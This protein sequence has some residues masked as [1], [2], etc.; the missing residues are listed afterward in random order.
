MRDFPPTVTA[1]TPGSS[2]VPDTRSAG[3]YLWWIVRQ[4]TDLMLAGCLCSL[5]WMLPT[6]LTPWVFGR[7]IDEGIVP[8]DPGR[9]ALWSLVLL[10]ITLVGGSSGVFY[11]TVVVRSWLV[12]SYG[13]TRLVT[14]KTARLGHVMTRRAPTGEVLSVSGGDGEQF[15]HFV[16]IVSRLVGNVVAYAA[17]A[18]IVLRI[19]VP[20]GLVVLLVAPLLVV[21]SSALLRPLSAAQTRERSRDS[22]LTSM[23][24]DIVAGLRILR[25]IGGE[26]IFGDNYARQSQRVR[27]A[28][29]QAGGWAALVEA[30]G[31]LL[32]GLFLVALLVLGVRAVGRG[33]LQIG[34]L[35]TF[36]GYA[37][38]LV[39]P[40]RVV[41][42]AAQQ[43]TRSFVSARKTIGVLGTPDPW[44]QR[45]PQVLDPDAELVDEAS[46][47]RVRP[48]LLTM[49]VS[50]VPDDSAAL[51]DRLGRYL[52]GAD[53][54]PPAD[55]EATGR[56]ARRSRRERER[57]RAQLEARD[58]ERAT[59]PWGVRLGG[60]DLAQVPLEQVRDTVLVSD[61]GSHV[62]AGTLQ[63]AV[64]PHGRLSR[65]EAEAALRAAAA[66]D[67]YDILPGGWQGVLDERGRGL[68]G[69]QRQRLVLTRAL[70]ADAPV[71]VLV[72]PT[73]A[74]DAHTEATIAQRL[75]GHRRG[76][77]TVVM[78]ASPL[79]LHHADVVALLE[80]GRVVASGTHQELAQ[81]HEGYRRTVLRGEAAPAAPTDPDDLP[82]T[83]EER[84]AIP[85]HLPDER[86]EEV[87][88]P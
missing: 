50:A 32:S 18:V 8:G 68:S 63:S 9:I 54:V 45:E 53:T 81:V 2:R 27:A 48:G 51:A 87:T 40:I 58:A 82:P 4:Q 59:R 70:A 16:E 20:L 67:V 34:Q 88:L 84:H 30:V 21:V 49:V 35:V 5:L 43:I 66:E 26:G 57:V 10:L 31:V 17:V 60:T 28:G 52:P 85:D 56:D 46:G 19:S 86:A 80:G 71:L 23:A 61:T 12:A 1:W 38:F 11:H 13:Q 72:E 78:T 47:L 29:V 22:E 15:G 24:T 79:L 36:L 14:H 37:L 55:E 33:E 77:T 3:R 39:Q 65:R 75:P 42:E 74:V 25:G 7:A 69:G 6:A 76:R 73:S 41:F 44:P 83:A 64:D 62:F